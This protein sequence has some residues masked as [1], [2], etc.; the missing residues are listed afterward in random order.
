MK[1]NAKR[2]RNN[3]NSKMDRII[4]PLICSCRVPVP[5]GDYG[6]DKHG[7]FQECEMCGKRIYEE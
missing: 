7:E 3:A 4:N 1:H 5:N 2:S 6:E